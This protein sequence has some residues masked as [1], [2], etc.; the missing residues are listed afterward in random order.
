[1]HF[2]SQALKGIQKFHSRFRCFSDFDISSSSSCLSL[3]AETRKQPYHSMPTFLMGFGLRGFCLHLYQFLL[4]ILDGA[5]AHFPFFKYSP[6]IHGSGRTVFSSISLN[7]LLDKKKLVFL[8]SLAITIENG[9]FSNLFCKL[10]YLNYQLL[11]L[12]FYY[13][14]L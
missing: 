4:S 10:C 7:K 11:H 2:N 14:L 8:S 6:E 13:L 9:N 5:D 1:M 12:Q 3:L